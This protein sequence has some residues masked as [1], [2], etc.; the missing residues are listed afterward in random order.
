MNLY[1]CILQ[2]S[3]CIKEKTEVQKL[4]KEYNKVNE[5][6]NNIK[7]AFFFSLID[8]KEFYHFFAPN[9]AMQII[10]NIYK[11][12]EFSNVPKDFCGLVINDKI[13]NEYVKC[14]TQ[15]N[16]I[17]TQEIMSLF[18]PEE[19]KCDIKNR[20]KYN[21]T[22]EKLGNIGY[23]KNLSILAG[24]GESV[25]K[26]FQERKKIVEDSAKLFP[27]HGFNENFL[28]EVYEK[29]I[30]VEVVES[31]EKFNLILYI[32]ERIIYCNIYDRIVWLKKEDICIIKESEKTNMIYKKMEINDDSLIFKHFPIFVID[33]NYYFSYK[34]KFELVKNKLTFDC[35]ACKLEGR[36]AL[37]NLSIR[38]SKDI[39]W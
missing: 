12:K 19:C 20:Y 37:L 27:L 16:G 10:K 24:N 34:E 26:Y 14:S 23:I 5:L 33:N 2:F 21:R 28:K 17:V 35:F 13:I 32:I 1:D 25:K 15:I 8:G 7:Y 18:S 9:I 30:P 31:V 3:D 29:D 6:R 38:D 22:S 36:D 39:Y 4:I 11:N